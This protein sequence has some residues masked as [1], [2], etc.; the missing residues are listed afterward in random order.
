MVKDEPRLRA[1]F[2]GNGSVKARL[3]VRICALLLILVPL[4]CAG[5]SLD[6]R[7]M[8]PHI[9]QTDAGFTRT[10]GQSEPADLEVLDDSTGGKDS[11]VT[12]D[13]EVES[14]EPACTRTDAEDYCAAL[15]ALSKVPVIDGELDCGPA[16]VTLE[17]VGWTGPESSPVNHKTSFAAAWREDGLYVYVQVRGQVPVPHPADQP[18]FCG[19]GIELYI[20]ADGDVDKAGNYNKSGAVQLVVSAPSTQEGLT[21][22]AERFL[23]GI[24]QGVWLSNGIKTVMSSDGYDL[25]AFITAGDLGLGEWPSSGRVGFDIAINLG[26]DSNGA[27]PNCG[28]RLGQYFLRVTSPSKACSGAPW[29]DTRAFC[30]AQL[31]P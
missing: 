30:I 4:V 16:L 7:P 3:I 25:E 18:I 24:S 15:P 28:S 10:L 9:N 17:G 21:L 29:C 26:G 23:N 19:D 6:T 8:S 5:C 2:Y 13:V 1:A 27:D 14:S 12:N 20:D 22:D 11:G 31:T